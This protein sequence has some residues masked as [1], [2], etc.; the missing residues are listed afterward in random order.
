[1]LWKGT[2]KQYLIQWTRKNY[3][4]IFCGPLQKKKKKKRQNEIDNKSTCTVLDFKLLSLENV[5]SLLR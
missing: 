5:W 4:V 2:G 1:M 3:E